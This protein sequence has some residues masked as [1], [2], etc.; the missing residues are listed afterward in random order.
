MTESLSVFSILSAALMKAA[1]SPCT[2]QCHQSKHGVSLKKVINY[3]LSLLSGSKAICELLPVGISGEKNKKKLK[4]IQ[5]M[6]LSSTNKGRFAND[7]CSAY[8]SPKGMTMFG[9]I[10]PVDL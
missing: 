5:Q 10:F 6:P 1:T 4:S 7:L 9:C 2:P 8:L 3:L